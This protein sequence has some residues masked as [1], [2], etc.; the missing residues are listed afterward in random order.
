M[1]P[2]IEHVIYIPV[3]L[4]L[5]LTLGYVMGARAVR[6]EHAKMKRRAKE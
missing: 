6:E 5:G 4:L 3:V 1:I 2:T